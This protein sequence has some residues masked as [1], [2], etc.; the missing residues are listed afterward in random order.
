[1]GRIACMDFL[2]MRTCEQAQRLARLH[3]DKAEQRAHD[4]WKVRLSHIQSTAS[5]P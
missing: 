3:I 4:K 2:E 5:Y 1:M